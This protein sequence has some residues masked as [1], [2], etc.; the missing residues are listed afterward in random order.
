MSSSDGKSETVAVEKKKSQRSVLRRFLDF[1]NQQEIARP[2]IPFIIIL[3][4]SIAL[5]PQYFLSPS[6]LKVV[7]FQS[8]PIALLALG[9][10]MVIIMGSIDLTPGSVSGLSALV[11]GLVTLST[12]N[13]TLAI[14]IA[15]L[16]G[17]AVGAINGLLV[18]KFKVYS[19][20]ATLAGLEIWRAVD[21]TITGGSPIYGLTQYSFLMND[22]HTFIP[23]VFIVALAITLVFW[24]LLTRTTWG[25]IIYGIGSNEEAVRLAGTH[26]DLAKFLAFTIAGS[27]YGLAGV[28]LVATGGYVV[29]PWTAYGYEL[30]AIAAAV[31]GGIALTGGTGHPIGPFFGALILTI[32]TD[33]L[34][35]MGITQYTI[36]EIII[37]IILIAA[38]PALTRGLRWVK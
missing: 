20:I 37:G 14:T 31:L 24:Y 9:E 5:S 4:A 17:L 15:I 38:A 3:V 8:A 36:Q 10:G 11:T 23:L 1:Y 16:A 34:I 13:I 21:L 33:I 22:F 18:S 29:D 35:I 25:R 12:G 26:A 30:Y 2:L 27:L 6:N 7:L 32:L 28:M 19:F